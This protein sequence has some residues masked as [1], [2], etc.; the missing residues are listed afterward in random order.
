MIT[1]QDFRWR[2]EFVKQH[3]KGVETLHAGQVDKRSKDRYG[4]ELV[5]ND[6]KRSDA[7]DSKWG[8][9]YIKV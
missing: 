8:W 7:E 1:G 2:D 6:I 9:G 5:N 3:L 4:L